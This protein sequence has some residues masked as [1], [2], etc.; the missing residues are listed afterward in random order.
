MTAFSVWYGTA[1]SQGA[2]ELGGRFFSFRHIGWRD[3]ASVGGRRPWLGS[4]PAAA[5]TANAVGGD[6]QRLR[7]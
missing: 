5:V 7:P 4:R 6:E 1:R 2:M 3:R